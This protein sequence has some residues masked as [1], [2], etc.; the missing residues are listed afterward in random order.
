MCPSSPHSLANI[1][2]PAAIKRG[3]TAVTCSVW[4]TKTP[5]LPSHGRSVSLCQLCQFPSSQLHPVR[6]SV[7]QE[8]L[9]NRRPLAPRPAQNPYRQAVK[10]GQGCEGAHGCARSPQAARPAHCFIRACGGAGAR[11]HSQQEPVQRPQGRVP[12]VGGRPYWPALAS[13]GSS[14]VL[15]GEL[16]MELA[17]LLQQGPQLLHGGQNSHPERRKK[18]SQCGGG[19]G[20][21]L[22]QQGLTE[23]GRCLPV[24]RSHSQ[25]PRRCQSPLGGAGRRTCREPGPAPGGSG[26]GWE[27]TLRED[28]QGGRPRPRGPCPALRRT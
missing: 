24:V 26:G 5:S 11:P 7:P 18:V 3:R 10:G 8:A 16:S 28:G 13:D 12:S 22:R 17:Q 4:R 23:S 25:A 20:E 2:P 14:G 19:R 15:A 21:G 27:G 1:A 9:L 6:M